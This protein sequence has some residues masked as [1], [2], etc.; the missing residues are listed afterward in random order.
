LTQT[1]RLVYQTA[2]ME[3]GFNLADPKDFASSIY[4]SVQKSLDLSPD[5]TIEEEDEVEEVEEKESSKEES[6]TS[7]DKDEL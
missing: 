4:K 7:Y 2:L 1:A 6:E 3:S 5:A